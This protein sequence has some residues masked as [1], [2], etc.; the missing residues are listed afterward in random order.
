MRQ[1]FAWWSAAQSGD[2]VDDLLERAAAIGYEGVDFL[3]EEHWEQARACGLDVLV[4]DGHD[5][6]EVGF[7]DPRHHEALSRQVREAVEKA[8]VSGIP[9]VAI[10]PGDRVDGGCDPMA[11]CV[12]GIALSPKTRRRPTSCS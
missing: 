6:I 2:P 1:G 12:A 4:I 10:A 7:N 8:S 5:S 3:P 11:A 9:F